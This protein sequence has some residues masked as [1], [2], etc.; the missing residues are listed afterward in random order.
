MVGRVVFF[1]HMM[2]DRSMWIIAVAI[3]VVIARA[4]RW[5]RVMVVVMVLD[6]VRIVMREIRKRSMRIS[7]RRRLLLGIVV[8]VVVMLVPVNRTGSHR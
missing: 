2:V 4:V 7:R 8:M 1:E 6:D 5:L 3:L